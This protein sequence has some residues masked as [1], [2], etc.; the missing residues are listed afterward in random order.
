MPRADRR[1]RQRHQDERD[2]HGGGGQGAR[3]PGVLCV[4]RPG[5]RRRLSHG[6]SPKGLRRA[7]RRRRA[8]SDARARG[9]D[10]TKYFGTELGAQTKFEETSGLAIVNGAH[11]THRL[12]AL[13]E[14]FIKRFVQ[15]GQCN[16][17]ETEIVLT[18]RETIE[19]HCKA[20]G[21][22]TQVD[23]RHKLCTFILK[24]PPVVKDKSKKCARG[25]PARCAAAERAHPAVR[26]KTLTAVRVR[27]RRCRLRA[28]EK[29]RI[30]EGE[31]ID[32]AEKDAKKKA[33]CVRPCLR[34][35]ASVR[36]RGAD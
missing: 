24:N 18:K 29:E 9:A 31:A 23:M 10:T 26:A 7:P 16:N 30:K 5:E 21:A 12:S 6:L 4:P 32:K 28:A 33:K 1:A 35:S 2:E 22:V 19:L 15:C 13:L 34:V 17:P 25:R 20:C 8:P 27:A 14:G 36:F 3:P 11:E